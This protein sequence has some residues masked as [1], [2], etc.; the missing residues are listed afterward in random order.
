LVTND[1]LLFDSLTR[2]VSLNSV[3][4]DYTWTFPELVLWSNNAVFTVTWTFTYDLT[5]VWRENFL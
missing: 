4:V 3:E 2:T 1:V 5:A